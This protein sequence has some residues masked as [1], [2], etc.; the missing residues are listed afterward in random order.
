MP[1]VS[2]AG[3]RLV[4]SLDVSPYIFVLA[5][6]VLSPKRPPFHS[7]MAATPTDVPHQVAEPSA[8]SAI[9]P[10]TQN[11]S[12]VSCIAL[13]SSLIFMGGLMFVVARRQ[14]LVK[15]MARDKKAAYHESIESLR[16]K[17]NLTTL[18]YA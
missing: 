6:L 7:R 12:V 13:A 11:I 9:H 2:S 8:V 3:I 4:V 18:L 1:G 5:C 15:K 17:P 10:P 16:Q 14:F